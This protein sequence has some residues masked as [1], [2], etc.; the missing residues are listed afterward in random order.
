MGERGDRE[1]ERERERDTGMER[2]DPLLLPIGTCTSMRF[3]R[4]ASVSLC[5]MF[6]FL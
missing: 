1:R 6:N 2:L 5:E 3:V 4:G